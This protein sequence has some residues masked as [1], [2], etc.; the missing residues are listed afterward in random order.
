MSYINSKQLLS[1]SIIARITSMIVED[2]IY[3]PGERLPNDRML[4]EQMGVSRTAMR[5]AL[6]SLAANGMLSIHRGVGTF[7]TDNPGIRPDP[8]GFAYTVDK[9][10]LIED[11]YKV[12]I[13]LEV[14]AM[15]YV[16]SNATDEE[17]AHFQ[18]LVSEQNRCNIRDGTYFLE[19]E[20][21]FHTAL[22]LATHNLVMERVVPALH[23]KI[24]YDIKM[25]SFDQLSEQYISNAKEWHTLIV[26]F[27]EKRDGK[28]AGIA[29]RYH[30]LRALED[31][32]LLK[33]SG[34]SENTLST[35][36]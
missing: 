11:W 3:K 32:K 20:R 29:M 6:K 36:T 12:R 31:I 27:L 9:I 10:R 1:E 16:A 13:I 7:V 21:K 4:A 33:H 5:E 25:K 34:V 14:E 17:I 22:A 30:M 15:E 19:L 35:M 23:D 24:Y 26:R 28:G 8:F 2:K 18:E